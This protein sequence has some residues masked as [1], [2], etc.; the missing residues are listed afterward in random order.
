MR[1]KARWQSIVARLGRETTIWIATVRRDGRPHLVPVWHI[2]LNEKIYFATDKSTQKWVNL[3]HNQNISVA[4]PDT[5]QVVMIEGTA[6]AC[7]RQTI[8]KLAPYFNDKYGWDF[9]DDDNGDFG[10]VVITPR[11]MLAWGDEYEATDG[12]RVF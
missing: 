3:I 1:N 7:T 10:L 5:E 4:L 6:N 8:D 9:R 12:T 11:K 2:Y